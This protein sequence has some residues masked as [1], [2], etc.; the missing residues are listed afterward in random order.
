MPESDLVI[1]GGGAA[2]LAAGLTA[3]RRGRQVV[4]LERTNEC[5]KKLAIA[6]GKKGNFTHADEPEIMAR[7]FNTEPR[8]LLPLMR[9]FPYTRI[10]GFFEELGIRHLVD[11]EGCIWPNP[12]SAP[13]LRD[14]LVQAFARA[15]GRIETGT[16][17]SSVR[18][19]GHDS[20]SCPPTA[21]WLVRTD[22]GSYSTD[23][24]LIATGGKSYPAT[25][26][27]G[28]GFELAARLG[29]RVEPVYSALASLVTE[30][31]F[32]ELSGITVGK[33]TVRLRI[34][35]KESRNQGFKDSS[36]GKNTARI[37]ESSN[38]EV[39]PSETAPF[40]FAG[41]SITG[42]AV[43]NLCGF[44]GK[45]LLEDRKVFAIVDWLP[46]SGADELLAEIADQRVRHGK[47]HVS[48]F[49]AAKS[50]KRLAL[51]LCRKAGI[52]ED[53]KLAELSRDETRR[54]LDVLKQT[55]I[56]VT[57][58]EPLA[59]ATAT[60]GGVARDEVNLNTFESRQHRGLYFAGEV[61]DVWGRSG[62][63]NLHFAWASGIAVGEA[64]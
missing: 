16:H 33:T 11:E 8:V 4:I 59:R 17:V 47:M 56:E 19:G 63:Y 9:R 44:A 60:G 46:D 5:G 34:E 55:E 12:K 22:A 1:V 25:G 32:A 10:V 29:I 28:D 2:G 31:E 42:R 62:G 51:L 58:T 27:S 30:G 21:H 24:V 37:P 18:P 53:R 7:Q 26:S 6:G 54:L 61:L 3:A 49:I 36:D 48:N 40:L 52:P 23:S 20:A 39:L 50:A 13:R 45:A 14:E 43:I 64:V 41:P 35:P 15:G 57:G 38:P